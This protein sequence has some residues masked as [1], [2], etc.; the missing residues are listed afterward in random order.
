MMLAYCIQ[1]KGHI[2]SES[3]QSRYHLDKHNRGV[4]QQ[5]GNKFYLVY[6]RLADVSEEVPPLSTLALQLYSLL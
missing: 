4:V 5:L 1:V 2:F 3:H 6:Y